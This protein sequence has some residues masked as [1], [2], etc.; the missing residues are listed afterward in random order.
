[1]Y[2]ESHVSSITFIFCSC[3]WIPLLRATQSFL[4]ILA[5][6][7]NP[8]HQLPQDSPSCNLDLPVTP[9]HD[10]QCINGHAEEDDMCSIC[11]VEFH[12]QDLVNK[13]GR[14]GHTFHVECMDKWLETCR[15]TCPLCRSF[16]LH[17][18]NSAISFLPHS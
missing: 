5:F 10:L 7:L 13:L 3:I 12:K 18:Y 16:L 15:F 1:M 17:Q 14:C 8:H 9:F 6:L 4:R 11:L 2:A